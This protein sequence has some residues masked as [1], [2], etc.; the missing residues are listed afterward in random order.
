MMRSQEGRVG[1][2]WPAR[3]GRAR[4]VSGPKKVRG[5]RVMATRLAYSAS[6]V[7]RMRR[8]SQMGSVR[9]ES[10]ETRGR[11][12]G[13]KTRKVRRVRRMRVG[14]VQLPTSGSRVR[15]GWRMGRVRELRGARTPRGRLMSD[16]FDRL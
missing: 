3:P 11:R 9:K 7:S 14:R 10:K 4:E 16:C 2:R 5:E 1:V 15:K 13:R 8:A 12:R 6:R